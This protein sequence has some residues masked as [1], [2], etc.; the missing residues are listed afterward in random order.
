MNI[1]KLILSF[2]LS[3]ALFTQVTWAQIASTEALFKQ[4]ETL[5]SKDKII[6][7]TARQDVA[8]IL[9]QMDVGPKMIQDRVAA[10]TDEEASKFA[11][12]I[13]TL[14]AGGDAVGALIGAVV[15][16]FVVLLITDVLGLTKVFN[17]TRTVR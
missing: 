2:I 12:Q 4:T 14:P 13:D 9:A 6:Q 17:F 16:I 1:S 10:M 11:N 15:F 3:I 5:S 7:F 8:K